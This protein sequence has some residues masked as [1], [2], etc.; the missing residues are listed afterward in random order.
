MRPADDRRQM[1]LAVQFEPDIAQHDHLVIILHLLEGA[2][3]IIDRVAVIAGEPFL[4]RARHAARCAD[5][6][7]ACRIISGPAQ[8][9][10]YSLLRFG[11]AGPMLLI[12]RLDEVSRS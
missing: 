9:C 2:L 12:D 6:P 1:V 10:P 11:T 4:E 3:E 8:Q 5:K 7:L